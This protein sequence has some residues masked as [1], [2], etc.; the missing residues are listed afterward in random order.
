MSSITII[1]GRAGTGKTESIKELVVT[2]PNSVVICPTNK[3][4]NVLTKRGI[5]AYTIHYAL[6]KPHGTGKFTTKLRPIIDQTTNKQ[7]IK[8]GVLQ[9]N[10][11]KEEIMQY[12][13]DISALHSRKII[14]KDI[15]YEDVTLIIDEASM[16]NAP[17]W[18]SLLTKFNGDIIAVGDE[19]QLPPIE[20]E[21]DEMSK[22]LKKKYDEELDDRYKQLKKYE[23][24]FQKANADITLTKQ[25]RQSEG[26]NIL[27]ISNLIMQKGS[28]TTG[29]YDDDVCVIDC[30]SNNIDVTNK[31]WIIKIAEAD[32]TI[33]F[34]NKT[35]DIINSYIRSLKYSKEFFSLNELEQRLP[36][37]D[38]KLYVNVKYND[39][40]NGINISKGE[41]LFITEITLD[42]PNNI[43][44]ISVVDEYG[45]TYSNIILSLHF[46]T[47]KYPTKG[48]HCLQVSYGYCITCHKAQ[49][50]QWQ[51]VAVIDEDHYC[52]NNYNQGKNWRY[53]AVTRACE[54]LTVFKTRAFWRVK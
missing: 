23:Y 50:S 14:D 36:Q 16:V 21:L 52:L 9:F 25:Y 43:A 54:V 30:E 40:M 4:K 8:N 35:C 13:F 51:S 46:V 49:G 1:K 24:Y 31:E 19:N 47:G 41:F 28:I 15:P 32:Q 44:N 18:E 48:M 34:L 27:T 20:S 53:T 29:Q 11:C 33:A 22:T 5:K 10:E 2:T 12:S 6:F 37:I 45:C 39:E 42:I 3:A 38:D 7:L 26:S 17:M